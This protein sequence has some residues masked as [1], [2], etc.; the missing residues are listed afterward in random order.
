MQFSQSFLEN[1]K[2]LFLLD[3]STSA[4][5]PIQSD[6]PQDSDNNEDALLPSTSGEGALLSFTSADDMD[7][8]SVVEK[9]PSVGPSKN[10]ADSLVAVT[11][12]KRLS[13]PP[14]TQVQELL[15][16]FFPGER[17]RI[18]HHNVCDAG[19]T[20]SRKQISWQRETNRDKKKEKLFNHTWLR[21]ADI[22]YCT[23]SRYWWPVFVEGEGV[24]CI[25]CKKHNAH[26]TQNK[27]EKFSLKPSG[28]FKSTAL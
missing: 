5:T 9:S 25:L 24:Y 1:D 23:A 13:N 8:I 15:E 27:Q 3:A 22:A 10:K 16:E 18:H 21:K 7:N 26:S 20:F 28:R 12:K 17:S 4:E 19:C 11:H 6:D 14:Q 2:V